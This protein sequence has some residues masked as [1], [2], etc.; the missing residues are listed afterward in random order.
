[1]Q[2]ELFSPPF[3]SPPIFTT[4]K[5]LKG[6]YSV[7]QINAGVMEIA[8]PKIP[9]RQNKRVVG[10]ERKKEKEKAKIKEK[11]D[12]GLLDVKIKEVSGRDTRV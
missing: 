2:L 10:R 6:M 11:K 9:N 4:F 12:G 5:V 1:M 8:P 3:V 7:F